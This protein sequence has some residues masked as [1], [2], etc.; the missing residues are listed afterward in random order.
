MEG[1][2]GVM[3]YENREVGG[4]RG[5]EGH[6]A[7]YIVSHVLDELRCCSMTTGCEGYRT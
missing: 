5:L 1:L 3:R 4:R 7:K 2:M 6:N